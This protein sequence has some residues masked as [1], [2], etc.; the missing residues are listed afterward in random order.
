MS[1]TAVVDN[2]YVPVSDQIIHF[3]RGDVIKTHTILINDYDDEC[4]KDPNENFFSNI[5][6]SIRIPNITVALPQATVTIDDSAEPEC[7][8]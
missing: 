3:G 6:L 5:T 8:T 2:D 4:E 1:F 7:G